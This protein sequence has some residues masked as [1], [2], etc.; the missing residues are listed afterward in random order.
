MLKNIFT[1]ITWFCNFFDGH[2]IRIQWNFLIK[3]KRQNCLVINKKDKKFRY[4]YLKNECKILAKKIGDDCKLFSSLKTRYFF[5]INL[6]NARSLIKNRCLITNNS[7][8]VVSKLR[9][10]RYKFRSFVGNGY[11]TGVFKL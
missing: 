4:K 9:I 1:S 6:P 7:N 2:S 10:S 11:I 8:S 3:M 5:A